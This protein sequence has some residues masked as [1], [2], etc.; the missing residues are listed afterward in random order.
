M[1]W[2]WPPDGPPRNDT[3]LSRNPS[4]GSLSLIVAGQLADAAQFTLEPGDFIL[5][6]RDIYHVFRNNGPSSFL[7]VTLYPTS[8]ARSTTRALWAV[9]GDGLKQNRSE[10]DAQQISEIQHSLVETSPNILAMANSV[11]AALS[12]AAAKRVSCGHMSPPQQSL[13]PLALPRSDE[14][15]RLAFPGVI[16][17]GQS[18][19][20]TVIHMRGK[21][22]NLRGSIDMNRVVEQLGNLPPFTVRELIDLL[23]VEV[24][25]VTAERLATA[26]Y[27]SASVVRV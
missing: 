21:E 2:V 25:Q 6:P 19:L 4:T 16:A 27:Q 3:V 22:V 18:V 13:L 8:I 10:L 26:L 12:N 24:G 9:I 1:F 17:V 5:I 15:L 20:G 14:L 7:G 11:A 23:A